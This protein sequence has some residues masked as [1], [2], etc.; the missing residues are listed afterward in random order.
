M[1]TKSADMCI[2]AFSYN[3]LSLVHVI[4]FLFHFHSVLASAEDH[5]GFQVCEC[6]GGQGVDLESQWP[7]LVGCVI[8]FQVNYAGFS[9]C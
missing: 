1:I 8:C 2:V 7:L 6:E 3:C 4:P 9:L 5:S